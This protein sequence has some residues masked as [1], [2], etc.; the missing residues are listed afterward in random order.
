MGGR[1]GGGDNRDW[2]VS[3]KATC[4]CKSST[5]KRP[6]RNLHSATGRLA[7]PDRKLRQ[8]NGNGKRGPDRERQSHLTTTKAPR[9][10]HHGKLRLVHLEIA[11]LTPNSTMTRKR[12]STTRQPASVMSR[13]TVAG[14]PARIIQFVEEIAVPIQVPIELAHEVVLTLL[15]GAFSCKPAPVWMP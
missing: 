5:G 7:T 3:H 2:P 11:G 10:K 6:K 15:S 1:P 4:L 13:S 9:Q 8:Q 14:V 12:I